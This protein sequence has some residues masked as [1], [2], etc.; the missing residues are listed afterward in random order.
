MKNNVKNENVLINLYSEPLCPPPLSHSE[1]RKPLCKQSCAVTLDTLS[2][3]AEQK[4]GPNLDLAATS[5][6]R[7]K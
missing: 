5:E 4:I 3:P 6:D 2:P 7:E 1:R